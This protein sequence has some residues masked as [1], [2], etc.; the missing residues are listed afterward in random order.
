MEAVSPVVYTLSFLLVQPNWTQFQMILTLCW[1]IHYCNRSIIHPLR[2]PSMADVHIITSVC[3]FG[4]NLFNGYTNGIW[5]G[6]H[7]RSVDC[8]QFWIGILIW[9]AGFI[10]NVY[11]DTVLFRL[12]SKTKKEESRRKYFIPQGGLYRF[13]SCPNYLSEAIEWIGF[14]I[15]AWPSVPALIFVFATIANLFPRAWKTH[16]WYK[17]KFESYPSSRKAVIPFLY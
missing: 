17:S 6:R 5:I 12:R 3:G 4:F 13:V 2:A 15:A 16:G 8:V 7:S 1:M 11:H 10:S 9:A 14:A